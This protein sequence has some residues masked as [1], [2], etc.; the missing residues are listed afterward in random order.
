MPGHGE[1]G[2][3]TMRPSKAR[4]LVVDDEPRYVKSLRVILEASGYTT[5]GATHPNSAVELVATESP[6]LVLL[7][8]VMPRLDGLE[9]CRR[10]RKFSQVPIIMLTALSQ[11]PSV[12]KGLEAGADDYMT[13]PFSTEELLA[14]VKAALRRWGRIDPSEVEPVFR[15]GKL[16]LDYS[17]CEVQVNGRPVH[18]TPTEYRIL[19]ELTLAAGTVLSTQTILEKVWGEKYTG[20][21]Q[22]V[23]RV[24]HRLRQKIE[25][26][27]GKPSYVHTRPGMGYL[28]RYQDPESASG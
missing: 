4:I 5:L 26:D 20:E 28:F 25:P 8:V 2:K 21:D 9:V 27:S 19:C 12:V 10:I 11:K 17:R 14:R 24:M 3:Y 6:D 7:D 16:E 23:A 22:L 15:E 18:L 1:K 13:K